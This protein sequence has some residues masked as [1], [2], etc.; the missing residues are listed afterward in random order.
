M[1]TTTMQCER[2]GKTVD[3]NDTRVSKTGPVQWL[4]PC[5]QQA[6]DLYVDYSDYL[7][8]VDAFDNWTAAMESDCV[9]Q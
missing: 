5:C 1:N 8:K 4:C 2:C 7:V 9:A 3:A 6:E